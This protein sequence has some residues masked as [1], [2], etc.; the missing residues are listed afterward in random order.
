MK[1]YAAALAAAACLYVGAAAADTVEVKMLN[2]GANGATMVFE[3]ALVRVKP[4][5]TVRF[6]PTDKGHNVESIKGMLPDGAEP[7]KGAI[8]AEVA[9]TFDK[10]GVYGVKCMPH[11]AMSMVGLII[12]GDGQPNWEA[13]AAVPH[14]GKAKAAF[15]DLF[16]KA[17]QP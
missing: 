17:A 12:V 14:T 2:K 8:N 16:A 6:V 11:Y 13:A 1:L 5:D 15:A 7:F 3:P 10:P 4:G 9:V